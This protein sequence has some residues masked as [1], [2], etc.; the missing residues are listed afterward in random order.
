VRPGPSP[1]AVPIPLR[2]GTRRAGERPDR[3]ASDRDPGATRP[4]SGV[5]A[6]GD[7]L[8]RAAKKAP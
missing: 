8:A 7:P 3:I 5:L 6:P 1:S 4:V 2:G